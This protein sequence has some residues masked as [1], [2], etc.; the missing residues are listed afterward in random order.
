M[1]MGFLPPLP[2][3]HHRRACGEGA[4]NKRLA[5]KFTLDCTLEKTGATDASISSS[6]SRRESRRT[7]KLE[8]LLE[9]LQSKIIVTSQVSVPKVI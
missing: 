4:K 6:S 3:W 5:L 9:G 8:M 1:E 2:P 7:E